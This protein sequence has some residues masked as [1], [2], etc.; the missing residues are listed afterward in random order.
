MG[1]TGLEVVGQDGQSLPL[2]LTMMAV[3][4]RDFSDLPECGWNTGTLDK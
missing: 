1:L 2:D 4:Q 3:T